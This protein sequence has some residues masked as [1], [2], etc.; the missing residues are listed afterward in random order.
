VRKLFLSLL[1]SACA[2]I[3]VNA[4]EAFTIQQYHVDVTVNK[5][6]SLDITETIQ[7]YFTESRHGIIRKIPYKYALAPL[8][9]GTE[10]A[11]RQL[12]SN[13]QAQTILE[14]I[15]VRDQHFTVRNSG[16]YKEIKIG[17]KDKYVDGVQQYII[18]YRMLNAIK[19]FKNH[20]EL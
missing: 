5:D 2:V 17:S 11:E 6:A 13:G 3:S 12:E 4:Q 16:N 1:L 19:F 15:G 20:S 9:A 14:N 18:H 7:V 8:P 10:K